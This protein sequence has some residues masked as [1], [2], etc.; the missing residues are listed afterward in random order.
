[1]NNIKLSEPLV[2]SIMSNGI[3]L[4]KHQA[5]ILG[6]TYPLKAGW[7]RTL[8]GKEISDNEYASLISLKGI[9]SK[10]K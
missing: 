5:I 1:M 10:K 7:I 3:G 4:N 6:M 8:I 9:T 2:R